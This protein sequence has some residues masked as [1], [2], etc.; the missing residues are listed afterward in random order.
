MFLPSF[1]LDFKID[2]T[3]IR[4]L[5]EFD[6]LVQKI[7][8]LTEPQK[9]AIGDLQETDTF[10]D[11]SFLANETGEDATKIAFLAYCLYVVW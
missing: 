1:V 8:P 3:P 4:E 2:N 10:K 9:V 6:A 7:K 5:N 11:I